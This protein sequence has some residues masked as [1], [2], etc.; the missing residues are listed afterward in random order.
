MYQPNL[1]CFRKVF[2]LISLNGIL[3]PCTVNVVDL[4]SLWDDTVNLNKWYNKN[5]TISQCNSTKIKLISYCGNCVQILKLLFANDHLVNVFGSINS[6]S[7][8]TLSLTFSAKCSFN[9]WYGLG[10]G[11]D[12]PVAPEKSNNV[13]FVSIYITSCHIRNCH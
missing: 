2:S 3:L 6:P 8:L 12:T 7:R 9:F 1:L 4:S 5:I 11:T 13:K 10:K